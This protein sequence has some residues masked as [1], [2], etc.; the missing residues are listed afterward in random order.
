MNKNYTVYHLHTEDSISG[1]FVDSCTNYK[2]YVNKAKELG[3]TALCFTEH[4][5]MYN[6]VEKKM[7]CEENG[8]KY[9]HGIECYLTETLEENI[10]DNYHTILIAKNEIGFK[11]VNRLYF[12]MSQ[13]DHFYYKP[14]L[15]FDEFL[16]ISENVIKISAC[17]ASPLNKYKSRIQE[18]GKDSPEYQSKM[19]KYIELCKHYDYY[20]I[21]Y[22]NCK[23]QIEYNQ[24]LYKISKMYGKPL[25]LAT[26]THSVNKYKAECRTMLQY[27]KDIVFTNEDEFDLTYKSYDEAV[28]ML[29][30][31][32]SLPREVYLQAL[33]ETNIMADSVE[34]FKLDTSIKYPILYPDKDEEQVM[35]DWLKIKY[36]YKVSHGIID[37]NDVRYMDNI[38]E[39]MRVFKKINMI[40]FMLFMS[41]MMTWC[42][43]NNIPTSPC[44]GSVGGSTVAYIG[45]II[46][47]DPVKWGTVFS[48]FANE[49][50]EEIGDIDLD[51]YKDQRQ[52]V[53]DHIINRFGKEKTA[54]ILAITTIDTKG[55]IDLL[56][57]AFKKKATLSNTT[58]PY[59]LDKIKEI[60]ADFDVDPEQTK[61]NYPDLFY[62]FEGLI[63]TAVSQSQHPAGIVASPIELIDNYG[64]FIGED[65]QY[66]LPINMDEVHEVGL[67]KY[68]I[69]GLKNIGVIRKCTEYIGIKYPLSHEMDWEDQNVFNDMIT[70]PIGIFQFESSYSASLLKKYFETLNSQ[71][72]K[73]TIDSM[74]L[75]NASLRPSGESYRDR[76]LNGEF[77][78]NPS[79]IIDELLKDNQGFLV[80]QEDTIKFLQQICGMSGSRADNVRRAIGRKQL[81]RLQGALPEIL[82]GYCKVSDKPREISEQE[83]KQFLQIIEDSSRYQ[84]GYNHS[85][86]YSMVGY[87]CAYF[88]YYNPLEFCTALLNCSEKP[89]DIFDASTLAQSKGFTIEMPKFRDSTSE[90]SCNSKENKNI[91]YKGIGSIKDVG[92]KCGDNLYTLRN[93]QY[94]TFIDL[95]NDIK[96]NSLA[97]KKDIEILTMINFFSEFGDINQLLSILP[98]YES[99]YKR[100]T[101]KFADCDKYNLDIAM[102]SSFSQKVTEK[103]FSKVDITEILKV[104][105]KDLKYTPITKI[106]R[107]SYDIRLL[108]Y[109]NIIIDDFKEDNIF[110]LQQI[111]FNKYGTPFFTVYNPQSGESANYKV[112]KKWFLQY[113]LNDKDHIGSILRCAFKSQ[114]KKKVLL[115]EEG[116]E[117][118]NARGQKTW[119]NTD[120]IEELLIAYKIEE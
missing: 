18:L 41:E 69:L 120:E 97:D 68:D 104:I 55:V 98:I 53:Y 81:D 38:R 5:T 50:R 11:E 56:G 66:I 1:G 21:Q 110:V 58:T 17:L 112:D 36:D 14:R 70:N 60:K 7:Y 19:N 10:R 26:D 78:N 105:F 54:Y 51:I 90:F 74:S 106:K 94:E 42:R 9:M 103:Q 20:E 25:I 86:G 62:C 72:K 95:L 77:E 15:S 13:K 61:L 101:I 119:V 82:E 47:L 27:G 117:V 102:V 32:D 59:T 2:L 100:N 65:G 64:M 88:R 12:T 8:I 83:A 107:I 4:G 75:V 37:G 91:I 67:S 79:S 71:N 6:W 49:D 63:G 116:K 89:T 44:R 22:H 39:E 93:N 87:L 35:W 45:D 108:G 34:E 46:D 111:N 30:M 109:T 33:E 43:D 115:D 76:L 24:Y 31:Q 23:D 52:L 113:K 3:Q 84:F 16:N 114:Y 96:L 28:K 40:G 48:R 73:I 118:L 85:T 29:E 92:K 99:L 57:R 80:Y